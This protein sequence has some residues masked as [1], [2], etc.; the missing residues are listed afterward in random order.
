MTREAAR[1]AMESARRRAVLIV[2][3]VGE[4]STRR[5]TCVRAPEWRRH[6]LHFMATVVG[7]GARVGARVDRGRRVGETRAR[8]VGGGVGRAASTS[9]S[10]AASGQGET[11]YFFIHHATDED[12]TLETVA[13]AHGTTAVTLASYNSVVA[14]RSPEGFVRSGEEV[15]IPVRA[16]PQ[17]ATLAPSAEKT[18]TTTTAAAVGEVIDVKREVFAVDWVHATFFTL[19]FLVGSLMFR[20]G[21]AGRKSRAV[22]TRDWRTF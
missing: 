16:S 18:T 22:S 7:V 19:G 13:R 9:T 10:S 11:R 8:H 21:G 20:D 4:A 2:S 5:W 1:G 12:T 14:S 15:V 17:R 3:S 6:R